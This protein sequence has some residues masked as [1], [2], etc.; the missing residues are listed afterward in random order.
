MTGEKI[1][2]FPFLVDKQKIRQALPQLIDMEFYEKLE[3]TRRSN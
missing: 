1:N 2:P 3:A